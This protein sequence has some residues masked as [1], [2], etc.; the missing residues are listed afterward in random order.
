MLTRYRRLSLQHPN[1][2]MGQQQHPKRARSI[3]RDPTLDFHC[4]HVRSR[5]FSDISIEGQTTLCYG[6]L[7]VFRNG[8][9]CIDQCGAD[10][11]GDSEKKCQESREDH[12]WRAQ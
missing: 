3:G 10:V 2:D 8:G 6:Q 7:S 1:R 11:L 4:K 12:N 5:F 9:C